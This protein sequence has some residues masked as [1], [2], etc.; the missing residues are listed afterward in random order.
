ME[1]GPAG[2]YG[3]SLLAHVRLRGEPADEGDDRGAADRDGDEIRMGPIETDRPDRR[4]PE[5]KMYPNENE[6]RGPAMGIEDLTGR[7]ALITGA[8]VRVGRRIALRLAREGMRL[9]LHV[10]SSHSEATSLVGEIEA[11]GGEARVYS[12]DFE[13][14]EAAER[15]ACKVLD[16]FGRID[17]L[18]NN[19]SIWPRTSIERVRPED[20][21]R[22]LMINLRAPFLLSLAIGLD[23]KRKG[24]G[25]IVNILDWSFE[26]PYVDQVPYSISKA[27]LAAATQ[28]LARALAP[29]V[30]VNGI[31][32]GPV[33]LAEG[34][35]PAAIDAVL[36]A[37]PLGR[38][39][40]PD[41]VAEGIVYLARAA[42]VT[43]AILRIDGGRALA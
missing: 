3:E 4:R 34:M 20:I 42:Y 32:P 9:A 23:M 26:R 28:G 8:A 2:Q 31:S 33:L 24:S 15:L 39:G 38:L 11:L 43:G 6:P 13:E 14:P 27:G 12:A 40:D 21:D 22:V 5:S 17:L 25:A 16:D 35:S 10:R 18:V 7:S 37:V 19:A 41:D 29:E 36:K 1:R 30:R